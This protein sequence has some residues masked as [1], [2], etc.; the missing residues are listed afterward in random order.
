[1]KNALKLLLA[2][3]IV[4]LVFCQLILPGLFQSFV[5]HKIQEATKAENVNVRVS[6]A[7]GVMLLAGRMDSIHIDADNA[8]IGQVRVDKL[9]LD[10][11]NVNGDFSALDARDG[12]AVTSADS[13]ELEGV[14]SQ[15]SLQELLSNKLEKIDDIETTMTSEKISAS[16]SIK[17]LGRKA[18]ITLDGIVFEE[19]GAV[20]F[21]MTRLDIRN[22][23][24]GKAVIGDF[25]G[26]ILLFDLHK[27][28]VKSEVD[29][30]KMQDGRVVIQASR[31]NSTI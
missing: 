31:H 16:G 5:A 24:F 3:I 2:L 6:S 22:A 15:E 14:I 27:M 19:D 25:F 12:S 28:P 8:V 10:G 21:H 9:T 26:D 11:I 7:F 1:M 29:D 13:L 4:F 23:V 18:D 20:F 30:V 17:L